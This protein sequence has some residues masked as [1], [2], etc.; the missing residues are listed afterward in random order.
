MKKIYFI[1]LLLAMISAGHSH[2]L[3][4]QQRQE[5]SDNSSGMIITVGLKNADI[6][7]S[8]NKAIQAAVDLVASRG[9]GTVQILPG[10]YILDDAIRLRSNIL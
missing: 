2:L 1:A 9:G 3:C 7:G 10:E 6:I 8:D 4:A 5:Q